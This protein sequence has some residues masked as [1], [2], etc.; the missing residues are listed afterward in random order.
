MFGFGFFTNT[1]KRWDT[2]EKNSKKKKTLKVEKNKQLTQDYNNIFA[3]DTAI[4]D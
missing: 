2:N 3:L 4:I 1:S